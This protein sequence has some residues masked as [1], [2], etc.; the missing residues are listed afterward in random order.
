MCYTTIAGLG[1]EI[2]ITI[3]LW[4]RQGGDWGDKSP[5]PVVSKTNFDIFLNL[6]RKLEG[7][8]LQKTELFLVCINCSHY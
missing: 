5:P 1:Y 7:G 8:A 4:R 2:G 6:L 3:H